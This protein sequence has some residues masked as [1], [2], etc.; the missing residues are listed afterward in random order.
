MNNSSAGRQRLPQAMVVVVVIVT[1]VLV[2]MLML[3][4]WFLLRLLLSFS[5][6]SSKGPVSASARSALI[7]LFRRARWRKRHPKFL[8]PLEPQSRFG[9]ELL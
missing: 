7:F 5:C 4:V 6:C 8:T 3:L 9:D 1:L 2:V